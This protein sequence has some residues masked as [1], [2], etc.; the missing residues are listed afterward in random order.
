MRD[1]YRML[2][3][4]S[5][6]CPLSSEKRET[7]T[8][9]GA[10]VDTKSTSTN[11]GRDHTMTTQTPRFTMNKLYIRDNGESPGRGKSTTA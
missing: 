7:L 6:L 3:Q 10:K 11:Q 2:C 5:R 4:Y 9:A 1:K 8:G